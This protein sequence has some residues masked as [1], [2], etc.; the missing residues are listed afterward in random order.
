MKILMVASEA[1]PFAKTGGLADVLG[2]LPAALAR[3]GTRSPSCCR[4][5]SRCC[6]RSQARLELAC[7]S[8][9]VPSLFAAAIDE[10]VHDGVRY[11][12][13]DCPQLYHRAGIYGDALGSY[14][15][16]HFASLP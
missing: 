11:F 2:A 4:N 14:P 3:L 16:N 1:A 9:S 13:V 8:P 6:R 12:F 15:D 10:V 7:P 5:I